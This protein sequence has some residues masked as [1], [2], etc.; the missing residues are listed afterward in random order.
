METKLNCFNKPKRLAS[1]TVS[2]PP[3]IVVCFNLA[4]ILI[5][6]CEFLVKSLF[7]KYPNGPFQTIM[8][9]FFKIFK[10]FSTVAGPIS[11]HKL[12]LVAC[13]TLKTSAFWAAKL[14]AT[15]PST[16]NNILTLFN[17]LANFSSF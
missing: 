17:L 8:S 9:A 5:K 6:F 12:F 7:S 3:I 13:S 15:A 11:T 2:P 10:Y 16:G 1:S 14:L 4:K